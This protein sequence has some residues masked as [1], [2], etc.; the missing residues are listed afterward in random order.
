MVLKAFLRLLVGLLISSLAL[1]GLFILFELIFRFSEPHDTRG[2]RLDQFFF[3]NQRASIKNELPYFHYYH[4]R[5]GWIMRPNSSLHYYNRGWSSVFWTDALGFRFFPSLP[6][7]RLAQGDF[8]YYGTPLT[9]PH[10]RRLLMVG[11]SVAFGLG[12]HDHE[13]FE[14]H[15]QAAVRHT[16]FKALG[17]PG[18]SPDQYLVAATI[19]VPLFRPTD[20]YVLLLPVNDFYPLENCTAY[21]MLKPIVAL[22]PG[23]P[24][25]LVFPDEM[26]AFRPPHESIWWESRF[27]HQVGRRLEKMYLRRL[28]GTETPYGNLPSY[29]AD[30]ARFFGEGSEER[31]ENERIWARFEFLVRRFR[32]LAAEHT[33][34][35]VFV[36]LPGIDQA[37]VEGQAERYGVARPNYRRFVERVR[38]TVEGSGAELLD[39]A[40]TF[41]A[42]ERRGV[43]LKSQEG[44]PSGESNRILVREITARC[45]CR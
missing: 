43:V 33:V 23:A 40:E 5:L 13:S 36:L 2:G 42:A 22:H 31:G 20:L 35:L 38:R 6:H 44:H 45:G 30:R 41:A 1:S 3:M 8:L 10:G 24:P 19:Y 12:V 25:K 32:Q 9:E 15:L 14:A 4:P 17:T 18:W 27:L 11:D 16:P 21:N 29:R 37:W 7:F 28:C 26:T 34:R 39:P